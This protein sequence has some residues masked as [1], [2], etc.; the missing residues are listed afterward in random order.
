MSSA[1]GPKANSSTWPD[2]T[3][4]HDADTADRKLSTIQLAS[5]LAQD[6]GCVAPVLAP[7]LDDL[8]WHTHLVSFDVGM[9]KQQADYQA[10]RQPSGL[11]FVDCRDQ[12][13]IETGYSRFD[14]IADREL[15]A[16]SSDTTRH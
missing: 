10:L 3:H 9:S 7:E 8:H 5:D 14:L 15:M 13:R 2:G 4:S 12:R 16:D 11:G 6:S 1:T